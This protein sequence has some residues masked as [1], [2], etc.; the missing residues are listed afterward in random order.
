MDWRSRKYYLASFSPEARDMRIQHIKLLS[1]KVRMHPSHTMP[2]QPDESEERGRY[3]YIISCL[4][5]ECESLEYELRKAE[6]NDD[7]CR[8]KEIK[9][10]VLKE[11]NK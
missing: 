10:N 7:Y 3:Q 2:K 5:T 11:N 4:C 6:R 9:Q 1:D 8:W